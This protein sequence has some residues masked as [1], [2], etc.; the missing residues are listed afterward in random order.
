M[1]TFRFDTVRRIRALREKEEQRLFAARQRDWAEAV[2]HIREIDEHR[3]TTLDR[4]DAL[5]R[6]SYEA[7]EDLLLFHHLGRLAGER[8][9]ATAQ[10]IAMRER[11]EHQR[12]RMMEAMKSR[13]M[14]D[15]LLERHVEA[16]RL[17]RERRE[18]REIS[19]NTI[20]RLGRDGRD[21]E[22]ME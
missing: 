14:M 5:R 10:E 18:V 9:D 15:R 3:E 19:D 12:G 7:G 8:E 20:M 21:H 16:E 4:I 2:A 6:K 11:L 13:R 1:T 17:E 22:A